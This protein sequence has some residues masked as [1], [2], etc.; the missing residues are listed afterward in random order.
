MKLKEAVNEAT[1]WCISEGI[2]SEFLEE[3]RSELLDM[4]TA[5]FNINIAK[6]V[7]QEEA[8]SDGRELERFVI[9]KAM[10]S[11]GESIEKIMLYTGLTCEKIENLRDTEI[12]DYKKYIEIPYQ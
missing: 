5:E 2:L 10:L 4:L 7:W 12:H 3:N 1:D 11:N 6:E 9:A 8:F